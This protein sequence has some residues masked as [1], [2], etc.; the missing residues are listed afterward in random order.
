VQPSSP[1]PDFFAILEVL[2]RHKVDFIVVGGVAATLQGA[3][4]MTMDVDIVHDRETSNIE[5]LLAALREL[6][7]FYRLQASR[8]LPPNSSH[9]SSRGHHLLSTKFGA[10]DVLGTI[11]HA[12]EW[13]ELIQKTDIVELQEGLTIAVLDLPTQ[14]AIKEEV[15]R[16]KDAI[17]LPILRQTLAE[18]S[19]AKTGLPRDSA[20]EHQDP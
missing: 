9:L 13:S 15:N 11:G 20:S 12:H 3:L 16:P 2:A 5:R 6:D 8:R 18:R 1:E 19:N 7:A 17:M 14:I 4:L 10:L